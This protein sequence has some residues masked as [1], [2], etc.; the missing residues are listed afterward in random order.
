MSTKPQTENL[1]P[2]APPG[3]HLPP[4]PPPGPTIERLT[5]AGSP[6]Q[7]TASPSV[8]ITIV[9]AGGHPGTIRLPDGPSDGFRKIIRMGSLNDGAVQIIPDHFADGIVI[10]IPSGCPGAVLLMWDAQ[11]AAWSTIAA[12]D[13]TPTSVA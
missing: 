7:V 2:H 10:N 4:P 6:W 8:D 11:G 13:A 9:G 1:G 5:P 12:W 3:P